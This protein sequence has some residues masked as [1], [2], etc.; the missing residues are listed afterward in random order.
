M[1]PNWFPLLWVK[2][3]IWSWDTL[4]WKKLVTGIR[5][6]SPS[7]KGFWGQ[8]LAAFG[9]SR[10]DLPALLQM[11]SGFSGPLTCACPGSL[12][13]G[14]EAPTLTYSWYI[15]QHFQC[16]PGLCWESID[17]RSW[18]RI[19]RTH[20]RLCTPV[21]VP[22]L[23]YPSMHLLA[24]PAHVVAAVAK[25]NV[26]SMKC[27]FVILLWGSC[28]LWCF[29]RWFYCLAFLEKSCALPALPSPEWPCR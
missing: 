18:V 10:Q 25:M 1:S 26:I 20:H 12:P 15:L 21:L 16:T 23:N 27:Y 22:F 28:S 6:L 29:P 2:C 24:A 8:D 7:S 13:S 11:V 14:K 9:W 4:A 17:F 19:L 5:A 3:D